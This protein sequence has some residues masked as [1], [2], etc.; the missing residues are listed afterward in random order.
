MRPY[1]ILG[2]KAND[3]NL[4]RIMAV[5]DHFSWSAMLV[6]PLWF[7][8][9]GMLAHAVLTGVFFL[10]ALGSMSTAQLM[11]YILPI[12]A[13]IGLWFGFESRFFYLEHLKRN[14]AKIIDVVFAPN[15]VVA[16]EIYLNRQEQAHLLADDEHASSDLRQAQSGAPNAARPD[17]IFSQNWDQK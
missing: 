7:F 8:W 13:L 1:F 12:F 3:H 16:E 5:G 10:F 15:P 17:F 4:D 11:P 14:G 2:S 6:T 9:R